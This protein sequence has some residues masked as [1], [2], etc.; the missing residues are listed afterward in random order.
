[1]T[2][3]TEAFS[4]QFAIADDDPFAEPQAT[5]QI[6]YIELEKA[7]DVTATFRGMAVPTPPYMP[8]VIA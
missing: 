6:D 3:L 2:A 1:M 5:N 4:T 7:L 8:C